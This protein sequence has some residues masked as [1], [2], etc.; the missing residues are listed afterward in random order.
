MTVDAWLGI[1]LAYEQVRTDLS[2]EA[3]SLRL[4]RALPSQPL[5][6][7]ATDQLR[8][9]QRYLLQGDGPGL[10]DEL[11]EV[12]VGKGI[13]AASAARVFPAALCLG[14]DEW[15]LGREC[16][17]RAAEVAVSLPDYIHA[18]ARD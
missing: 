5:R 15:H 7:G 6:F 1:A 13:S 3:L 2:G 16:E 12:V 18:L 11:P 14:S 4:R 17:L 10:R 9:W 8:G